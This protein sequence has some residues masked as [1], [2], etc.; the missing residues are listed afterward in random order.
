MCLKTRGGEGYRGRV[1][2]ETGK[3]EWGLSSEG[4]GGGSLE[5]EVSRCTDEQKER[6]R[7][8]ERADI[9][10]LGETHCRCNVNP[11]Y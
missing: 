7:D 4:G 2:G 5:E 3:G 9:D 11:N 6:E 8:R 1:Q 10:S